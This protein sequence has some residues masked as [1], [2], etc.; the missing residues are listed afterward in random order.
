MYISYDKNNCTGY[1]DQFLAGLEAPGKQIN[2]HPFFF[3]S[4]NISIHL[5]IINPSIFLLIR[6]SMYISYNKNNCTGYKD[7]FLAGLEAPGKQINIHPFFF[8]SINISIHL[9]IINPSIFLLI[10]PSMYISYNKN[11]CT[12]YK[13][14]FLAG[15]EASGA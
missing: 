8:Q 9:L 10:R 13:D 14:Q 7:Q 1:K 5:L 11:N 3:Q 15:L 6:P 12:G 4:I 2:I